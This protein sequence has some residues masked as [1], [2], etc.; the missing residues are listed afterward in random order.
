MRTKQMKINGES[1]EA[2]LV[3]GGPGF[4][5]YTASG[6]DGWILVMGRKTLVVPE[7]D[8]EFETVAKYVNLNYQSAADKPAVKEAF[9][10]LIKNKTE[11]SLTMNQKRYPMLSRVLASHCEHEPI[12]AD[13]PVQPLKPGQEAKDKATCGTCGLSWDDGI[14]TS[15]TPAPGARCPFE[16]FHI[17][18]DEG[19]AEA[20]VSE[21][22]KLSKKKIEDAAEKIFNRI[23]KNIQ[24]NIMDLGKISKAAEDV[25]SAGGTEEAAEAAMKEAIEK[26]KIG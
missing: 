26:Y 5:I 3:A 6:V 11:G 14:S 17:C 25:L 20:G 10:L 4:K 24:F 13:W 19:S 23:G 18:G 7:S 12:P 21:A 16:A 2:V 9:N 1:K 22:A 15:M 8:P